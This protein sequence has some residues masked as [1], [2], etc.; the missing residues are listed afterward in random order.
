MLYV[1]YTSITTPPIFL[2]QHKAT[3]LRLGSGE[4]AVKGVAGGSGGHTKDPDFPVVAPDPHCPTA[5]SLPLPRPPPNPLTP[6]TLP[7]PRPACGLWNT[8]NYCFK[9][10]K[11]NWERQR[12]SLPSSLKL[13]F[14]VCVQRTTA[15]SW[16]KVEQT[17]RNKRE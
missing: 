4:R 9:D 5:C 7:Q 12:L 13:E 2:P 11:K 8:A 3:G 10:N 15:I 1:N 16:A 17:R 14:D 6:Y